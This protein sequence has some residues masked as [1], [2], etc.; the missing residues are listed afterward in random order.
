VKRKRTKFWSRSLYL[1]DKKENKG[2]ESLPLSPRKQRGQK[3]G[4]APSISQK[5]KRTKVWSRSLSLPENKENKSLESLPLSPREK[6]F[7]V[8]PSPKKQRGQKFGVAPSI[9]QKTR[10]IEVRSTFFFLLEKGIQSRDT[11]FRYTEDS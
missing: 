4:V 9:S 10:R 2:L 7:G 1:P 5:T 11:N 8:S 3:F 6:K